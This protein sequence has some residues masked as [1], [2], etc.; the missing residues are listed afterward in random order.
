MFTLDQIKA[1]HSKVKSGVDFP[2][3]IQ[4][5]KQL[6]I[7]NYETFVLDGHTDFYGNN[8]YKISSPARYDALAVSE[9]SDAAQFTKELK[10]HQQGKSDY[11]YFCNMS[12]KTG[13]EKWKV[14]MSKMTCTYFDKAG[15]E[16]LK[17]I[18]PG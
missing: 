15:N 18:I 2:N 1:A 17:E 10:E 11:P 12:A 3:Y 5:L 14:V 6:G 9:K 7:T 16:M 8:N 13:V 4:E